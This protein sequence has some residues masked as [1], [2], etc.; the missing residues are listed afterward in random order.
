MNN[1]SGRRRKLYYL[2]LLIT[3]IYCVRCH[4]TLLCHGLI[5]GGLDHCREETSLLLFCAH[6]DIITSL[7]LNPHVTELTNRKPERQ[8][9]QIIN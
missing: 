7:F 6:V 4:D 2:L 1:M 5:C 9:G 8:E 3:H